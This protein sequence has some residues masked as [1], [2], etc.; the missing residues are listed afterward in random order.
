MTTLLAENSFDNIINIINIINNNINYKKKTKEYNFNDITSFMITKDFIDK[1]DIHKSDISKN[2]LDTKR[3][4]NNIKIKQSDKDKYFY[5]IQK[6]TLFWC[7]YIMK[8]GKC[9]YDNITNKFFSIEK[10]I[11]INSI[12][13]LREKKDTLKQY[14][15]KLIEL[16]N[17]LLNDEKI[18]VTTML[19]LCVINKINITY[20]SN[21]LFYEINV[22]SN[23]KK[24]I[25][26]YDNNRNKYGIFLNEDNNIT[27]FLN[28]VK[29]SKLEMES[30]SK[31]IKS[32]SAY[33]LNDLISICNKLSI[34]TSY[35]GKKRKKNE[36]YENIIQ[37][38][39]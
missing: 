4:I 37:Q 10:E 1:N 12:L 3:E 24:F 30:I 25:I 28:N 38:I 16:E 27:E 33:K 31:P 22:S 9:N 23:E 7:F 15:I 26:N 2:K 34:P 29:K 39:S 5:P 19:A 18:T 35:N 6:D 36:M 11:K 32:F 20:I 8:Y 21:K 17:N 14:K 13:I